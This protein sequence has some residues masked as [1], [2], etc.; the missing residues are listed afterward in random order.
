[1][2]LLTGWW[3][4]LSVAPSGQNAKQSEVAGE[5]VRRKRTATKMSGTLALNHGNTGTYT[6]TASRNVIRSTTRS[7]Q[8]RLRSSGVMWSLRRAA[9]TRRAV[10]LQCCTNG[11]HQSDDWLLVSIIF[12]ETEVVNDKSCRPMCVCYTCSGVTMGW[13]PRLVTGGPTAKG[14]PDRSRVFYDYF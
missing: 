14:A 5:Y 6:S 9:N 12:W 1:M 3:S 13:L 4:E 10:L 8:C 11:K 2:Q 7:N